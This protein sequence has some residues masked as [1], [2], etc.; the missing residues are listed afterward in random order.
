MLKL[1]RADFTRILH[2]LYFKICMGIMLVYFVTDAILTVNRYGKIN[3]DA[4]FRLPEYMVFNNVM[5]II[6]FYAVL[7]ALFI[8]EDY[9]NGTLRNKIIAGHSRMSIYFSNLIVSSVISVIGFFIYSAATLAITVPLFGTD[10]F[11]CE[12]FIAKLIMVTVGL[13]AFSAIYNA[14]GMLI[15][16]VTLTAIITISITLFSVIFSSLVTTSLSATEHKIFTQYT[17]DGIIVTEKVNNP[18]YVYGFRR[19][20]YKFADKALPTSHFFYATNSMDTDTDYL[21]LTLYSAGDIL[22]ITGVGALA[23]RRKNLK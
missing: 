3:T 23:F 11:N 17:P 15:T 16:N 7:F 10:Y 2:S 20:I 21:M 1:L 19:Q 9:K 12:K 6:M 4:G 22:I 8:G 18:N 14:I 5:T 13:I